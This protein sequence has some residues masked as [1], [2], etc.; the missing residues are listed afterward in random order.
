MALSVAHSQNTIEVQ[1]ESNWIAF[2]TVFNLP[3]DGG[4]VNFA[5]QWGLNDAKSTTDSLENTLTLQPNY[6]TYNAEDP[7]W[8][9]PVT[10]EGN[11]RMIAATFV[12]PGSD[13]NGSDFTFTGTV[14]SY[15]LD[16]AYSTRYF[17]R[18]LDTVGFADQLGGAYVF[19]LPT[20]GTFSVTV[21]A[22]ELPEGLLLQYGFEVEGLNA[23]PADEATLGSVVL[24]PL[25][26]SVN[27]LNDTRIPA[28]VFPNPVTDILTIQSESQVQSYQISTILGERVL[29]GQ[30]TNQIDV[31]SLPIGTY[32][33]TARFDEGQRVIRFF[34]R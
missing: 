8:T 10:L 34:K 26:T 17:V 21:P 13:F 4:G 27:E 11:K 30:A 23:N 12:E 33:V 24:G 19:D 1:A 7:F 3:A 32:L 31:S 16:T 15:T 20:S 14:E 6:N 2:M 5:T 18:A 9:N 29:D 28:T 25:A 22:A